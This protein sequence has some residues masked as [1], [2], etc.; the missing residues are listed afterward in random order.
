MDVLSATL[1]VHGT[2]EG[3]NQSKTSL[4]RFCLFCISLLH[5]CCLCAAVLYSAASIWDNQ[6]HR[7]LPV[8]LLKPS[9]LSPRQG[10]G[11]A[12]LSLDEPS[13][14]KPGLGS[15]AAGCSWLPAVQPPWPSSGRACFHS[16]PHPS[17][18]GSPPTPPLPL[19][20]RWF[21]RTLLPATASCSSQKPSPL[22]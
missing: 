13:W 16:C 8:S 3:W 15:P 17:F 22:Y 21:I 11:A 7:N 2:A 5:S 14:A 20:L 12:T 9:V 18:Q 6:R 4:L 1:H 19:C 10:L